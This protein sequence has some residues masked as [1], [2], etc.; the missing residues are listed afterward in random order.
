MIIYLK[1]YMGETLWNNI[2]NE[3][4]CKGKFNK[5]FRGKHMKPFYQKGRY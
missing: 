5:V 2:F 3:D 1:N 4:H